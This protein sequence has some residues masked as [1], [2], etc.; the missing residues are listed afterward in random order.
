MEAESKVSVIVPT[1]NR[2]EFIS[3]CLYSVLNQTFTSLELIVVDDGSTDNTRE[4]VGRIEDKRVKYI[5][6]KHSGRPSVPRNIGLRA[7]KGE[8]LAFLDSDDLWESEKLDD[9]VSL[10]EENAEI[11]LTYAKVINFDQSGDKNI[12]VRSPYLKNGTPKYRLLFGNFIPTISVVIR[13]AFLKRH[14]LQFNENLL[15]VEDYDL[16]LRSAMCGGRFVFLDKVLAKHRLHDNQITKTSIGKADVYNLLI[17]LPGSDW[18]FERL[19]EM[20]IFRLRVRMIPEKV[21][22]WTLRII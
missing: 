14:N 7:A 2:A 17:G 15:W 18:F 5:H 21:K 6:V 16:W 12:A 19:K 1:Y 22:L 3:D 9:Q 4:I 13:R 11:D 20:A 8:Y 10:M